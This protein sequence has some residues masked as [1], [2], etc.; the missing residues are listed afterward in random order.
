MGES[1]EPRVDFIAEFTLK[2]LRLK[3]D[4]WARLMVSDEQRN[5]VTSFIERGKIDNDTLGIY[6]GIELKVDLMKFQI[7]GGLN[8][9][10]KLPIHDS[11]TELYSLDS[12][13][14]RYN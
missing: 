9:Q 5:F 13:G 7:G 8:N 12:H 3:P 2:S 11:G 4:K 1:C 10:F 14:I 6:L